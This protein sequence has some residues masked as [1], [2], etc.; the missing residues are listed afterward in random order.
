VGAARYARGR[1]P[2]AI[3][4]FRD[5]SLSAEFVPFL[6]TPAYELIV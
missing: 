2:A 6:T 3:K 5:L 4:L 1:F